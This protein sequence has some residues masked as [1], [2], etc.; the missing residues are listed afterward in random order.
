MQHTR[1]L[2]SSESPTP[3]SMDAQNNSFTRR[4]IRKSY[5]DSLALWM[6]STSQQEEEENLQGYSLSL[7][8]P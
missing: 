5:K 7:E 3:T 2:R 1:I 4:K 6:Q 8:A